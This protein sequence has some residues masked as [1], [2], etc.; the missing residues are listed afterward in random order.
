MIN[1]RAAV[2]NVNL[3]LSNYTS[4]VKRILITLTF[5]EKSRTFNVFNVSSLFCNEYLKLRAKDISEENF[6]LFS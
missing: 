5:H 3:S 4:E 6:K 2:F 1:V